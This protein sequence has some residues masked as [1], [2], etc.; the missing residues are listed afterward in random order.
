MMYVPNINLI[1]EVEWSY[2]CI[3]ALEADNN[4]KNVCIITICCVYGNVFLY[5]ATCTYFIQKDLNM[6]K[7][8]EKCEC[9]YL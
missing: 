3:N 6:N 7:Y 9:E 2:L 1:I 8:E 4:V 5:L